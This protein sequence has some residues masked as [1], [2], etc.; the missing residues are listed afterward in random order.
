MRNQLASCI[1]LS[2]QQE[3]ACLFAARNVD[4]DV[5]FPACYDAIA[6]EI[7]V[8]AGGLDPSEESPNST[9]HAAG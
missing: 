1:V 4:L 5:L 6:Q 2:F 7:Q 9:E 8:I 3:M